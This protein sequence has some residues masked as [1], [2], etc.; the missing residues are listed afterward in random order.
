MNFKTTLVLGSFLVALAFAYVLVR[1]SPAL[2]KSEPIAPVMPTDAIAQ[3]LIAADAL[4]E[5]VKIAVQ[6]GDDPRLVFEKETG[7]SAGVSAWK[8]V[9]PF[10]AKASGWEVDR[11]ARDLKDLKY[12]ISHKAGAQGGLSAADAGLDPPHAAVTLMDAADKSV[13][14]EIGKPASSSGSYV[15]LA[16]S[17]TIVVSKSNLRNLL[18]DKAVGYRDLQVWN[19]A[20]DSVRRIEIVDRSNAEG[21]TT[22]AFVRDAA[23]WIMESPAT[24]KATNKVNEAVTAISRLRVTNWQGDGKDRLAGYGLD[25]AALTVR[26]TV[27][28]QVPAA[29]PADGEPGDEAAEPPAMET[30]TTVHELHVSQ[31]TPIGEDTKTHILV[32]D[33][34]VVGLVMKTTTD[35]LKPVM[36]EWRDMKVIPAEVDRAT[37]IELK[38]G[39]DSAVFVKAAVGW[40]FESGDRAE[41]AEIEKLL[42]S[43]KDLDAAVFLEAGETDFSSFGLASPQA[44]VSLTVPGVENGE[45]LSIGGFTDE[46]S[47]R[48]LYVRRNDLPSAAKVRAAEVEA[49]RRPVSVYRDRTVLSL[50]SGQIERLSIRTKSAPDPTTAVFHKSEGAWEMVEPVTAAVREDRI[51]QL[52][53]SLGKLTATAVV[54]GSDAARWGLDDPDAVLGVTL[55]P[56]RADA[57]DDQSGES[58]A[59]TTHELAFSA[60]DGKYYAKLADRET[61][62][63]VAAALFDQVLAEMRSGKVVDFETSAVTEFS[64]EQDGVEHAFVR[65]DGGWSYKAEPDLPLAGTRVENLLLQVKDLDATRFVVHAGADLSK[66]GLDRP[67]RKVTVTSEGGARQV[68]LISGRG[69]AEPRGAGVYSAIEGAGGVFIF[70]SDVPHRL[71]VKLQE[72]E[73]S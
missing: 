8:I 37:R 16:G 65:K 69:N 11:I 4:G 70:P 57:G 34:S 68:L 40:N 55:A 59:A 3:E 5:V 63:E 53:E 44:A 45:R 6:K 18:K 36:A 24:A 29:K 38:V 42:N 26:L 64:I 62:Y 54:D 41:Q 48:M 61:V 43:M 21:P 35:K 28:E 67:L 20:P 60:K 7:E 66:Y 31:V 32:G 25:P 33:E 13:T 27:E 73:T 10:A 72:L 56:G 71:E 51:H 30:K 46:T 47:K 52:V 58:A 14:V 49:I 19:F 15:R 2:S 50:E 39:D 23:R 17:D 9:E 12:E 1:Q 22:Y